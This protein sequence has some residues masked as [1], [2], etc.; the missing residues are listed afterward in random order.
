MNKHYKHNFVC[1]RNVKVIKLISKDSIED[2]MLRIGQRKLKLEQDMTATEEGEWLHFCKT[3][4]L[5]ILKHSCRLLGLTAYCSSFINNI[6]VLKQCADVNYSQTADVWV[7]FCFHPADEDTIPDDMASL[8]KAS[9]GLWEAEEHWI[10]SLCLWQYSVE[11]WL[12]G[13]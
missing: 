2:A 4:L 6:T 3:F 10:I 12:K 8:L 1:C 13:L 11:F 7:I 9:L 5:S